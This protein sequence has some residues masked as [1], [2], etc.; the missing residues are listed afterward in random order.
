MTRFF[1]LFISA[2]FHPVFVNLLSL[3]LLFNL[4]PQL[5]FGIPEKLKQFMI[6]F[7]FAS[8]GIIPM[9][10]V[11][12]LKITGRIKS[13]M[14]HE[15]SERQLPYL[16]TMLLYFFCYYNFLKLN[17]NAL[18]LHYLLG[19]TIVVMV[20]MFVN[21]F[22]KISIHMASLGA[23]TGLIMAATKHT[24]EDLR[25]YLVMAFLISGLVATARLYA[26]AHSPL[27]ISTG[28]IVGLFIMFFIL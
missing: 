17:A 10:M 4:F 6:L 20:V 18:V 26:K 3:W 1:Q 23:L 19:C 28:F 25:L 24:N 7:V 12:V 2:I 9:V 21:R 16:L 22:F 5:K 14:L 8:T 15:T 27:Q 11:L 13:I